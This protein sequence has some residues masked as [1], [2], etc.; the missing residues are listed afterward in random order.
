MLPRHLA[1]DEADAASKAKN[2][3]N[4]DPLDAEEYPADMDKDVLINSKYSMAMATAH[5]VTEDS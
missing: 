1:A 2:A 5:Q 3:S 4:I